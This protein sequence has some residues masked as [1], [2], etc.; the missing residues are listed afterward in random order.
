MI[1]SLIGALA[2][3]FLAFGFLAALP[4]P[5]V[6][7]QDKQANGALKVEGKLTDEDPKDKVFKGSPHKVHEYKMKANTIYVI[8]MASKDFDS[9]LRLEN[10]A[11]KQVALND[12]SGPGTL[13]SRIVYKA[14]EDGA[15]RI[16]ATCLDKKPGSYTL[17]AR[18]GT[19]EELAKAD[20]FFELIGKPA[21]QLVGQFA[22][23][24]ETKK[25]SELKGKVVL[26]DFWA[27]WCGPCIQTFP[28]LREWTK[29]Y[30]KDG[31]EI[32]GVTTY[33]EQLG[34][35]KEK[36]KLKKLES[37]MTAEEE[38]GMLKEFAAYH[39]LTHRL[40][41]TSKENWGKAGKDFRVNG[42]PHA[43]LI[44]RTGIVRMV[45]VGSGQANAEDLHNEIKKLVAE[46]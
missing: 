38:H 28:H 24:G 13:D 18:T 36:G 21:P 12:D 6:L 34:F 3:A 35:D 31:F 9:V 45:R 20:P 23:N 17:T 11:G 32:L 43:V 39:N 2:I 16:I 14:L 42:I 33:Y 40:L 27:V 5:A 37:P 19:E 10:S 1:R 4:L 22:L 46:K 29:E 8:D 7:A 25:L 41:A 30:Q 15:Y 26:V 44:D